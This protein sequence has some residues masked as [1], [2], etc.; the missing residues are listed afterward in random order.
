VSV[1]NED[2][3]LRPEVDSGVETIRERKDIYLQ[4]AEGKSM[5]TNRCWGPDGV[6]VITERVPGT[7]TA[8]TIHINYKPR[9]SCA[10]NGRK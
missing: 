4:L 1:G 7:G 6:E 9:H 3:F 5:L 2:H 10:T 8:G